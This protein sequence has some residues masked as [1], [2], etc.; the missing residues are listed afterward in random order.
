MPRTLTDKK[1]TMKAE[2]PLGYWQWLFSHRIRKYR[3]TGL[4]EYIIS[5]VIGSFMVGFGIALTL[6]EN[7]VWAVLP[8]AGLLILFF[9]CTHGYYRIFKN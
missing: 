9:G 2:R 1:Q 7:L 8:S 3:P 4:I 5:C 6:S